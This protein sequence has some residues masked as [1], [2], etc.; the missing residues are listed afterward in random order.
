[1]GLMASWLVAVTVGTRLTRTT[2]RQKPDNKLKKQR[3]SLVAARLWFN[4]LGRVPA[5]LNAVPRRGMQF[6]V[7]VES[8]TSV[9][10]VFSKTPRGVPSGCSQERIRARAVTLRFSF[11]QG[12]GQRSFATDSRSFASIRDLS[13]ARSC[14]HDGT[15]VDRESG[16]SKR[17]RRE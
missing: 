9:E 1:M 11:F 5:V 10:S 17:I 8:V 6:A 16:E 13:S 15:N 12:S 4:A 3:A 7:S 14:S 2:T